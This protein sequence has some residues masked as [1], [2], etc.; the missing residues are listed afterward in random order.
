MTARLN[1]QRNQYALPLQGRPV[2]KAAFLSRPNRFLVTSQDNAHGVIRA[3]L[4]NP[5]RLSELLF[6]GA[7]LH[8]LDTCTDAAQRAT[9]FTVLA[10]ERDGRPVMLHTHWCNEMAQSLL[11]HH[12]VPGLEQA[13]IIRRE[14]KVGH[15]RFDFLLEDDNGEIYL[16]VKSCTLFG[17]GV[18]MFPDAVTERGKR[19]LLELSDLARTGRRC[20]VLFI[21]QTD[22]VR[23][24]MPDYHTDLAFAQTMLAVREQV[25]FMALPV[26]WTNMLSFQ[27][28]K[29]LLP[30]PWDFIEGEANDRGAYLAVLR[31]DCP[32]RLTIGALGEIDFAPGYYTYVGS[33]MRGLNARIARHCR[34]RKQMHWH[35]DYLRAAAEVVEI[36]PIRSS[37]RRECTLASDLAKFMASS[38]PCFGCSDCECITHLFFM[39]DNPLEH[40]P[41]HEWLQRCRMHPPD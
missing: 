20:H 11:T 12:A 40:P 8:I 30:I 29:S 18:A 17:N 26:S 4:P 34:K 1:I 36:L 23:C 2:F 31:L 32:E 13:R 24:F 14:V 39:P 22:Q 21:V 9:R 25:P 35:L 6:P 15:S 7:I 37:E 16:E 3:F 41:F 19:H 27:P 33:A 28:G 5:G 10:V 38:I